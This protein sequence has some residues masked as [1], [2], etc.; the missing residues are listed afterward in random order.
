MSPQRA[1]VTQS[2][3]HSIIKMKLDFRKRKSELSQTEV[4]RTFFGSDYDVTKFALLD[5]GDFLSSFFADPL[6]LQQV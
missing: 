5:F 1:M 2:S 3:L 4:V 6:K